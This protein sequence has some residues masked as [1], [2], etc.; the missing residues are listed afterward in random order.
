MS[1]IDYIGTMRITLRQTGDRDYPS[2]TIRRLREDES[3]EL[4]GEEFADLAGLISAVIAGDRYL[5]GQ[6][7]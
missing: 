7:D 1:G 6:G 5:Q 4:D 2:V 3:L